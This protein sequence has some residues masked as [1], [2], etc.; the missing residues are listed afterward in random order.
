MAINGIPRNDGDMNWSKKLSA[1]VRTR[2]GSLAC[3]CLQ[4]Q[5]RLKIYG[6]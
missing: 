2:E 1:I 3:L 5:D 4:T 6:I